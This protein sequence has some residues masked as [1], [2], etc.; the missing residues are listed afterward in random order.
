MSTVCKPELLQQ[1]TVGAIELGG[2]KT[3]VAIGTPAGEVMDEWRFPTTAPEETLQHAIDWLREKSMPRRIGVG[4]FG[5][6]RL[7]R[8]SD[9]DVQMLR[10]PKLAWQ[11]FPLGS[12]L[13]R[14]APWSTF[15][16]DT[17]V[18]AALLA[19]IELGAAQNSRNAVYLTIGTGIG[20]GVWSEGQVIHGNLHPEIGHLRVTR[21]ADDSFI[22]V[23]PFH[24]DCLEGLASGPAIETRW[25]QSA[26]DLPFDHP[27]WHLEAYYLA[28]G[29][30]S[31]QTT[32]ATEVFVLGGGVAQAPG[33]LESIQSE[34]E[35][36]NHGYFESLARIAPAALG[37]RAGIIGALLLCR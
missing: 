26:R 37:Q 35:C 9:G 24:R 14:E 21:H 22:G 36:L 19:E 12:F 25:Q 17:D 32:L 20:G 1:P 8:S 13:S 23:C 11:H 29:L 30:Y 5:P 16:W 3:V 2:T 33:L 18:N 31:L 15:V 10:T 4:S 6:I 27:A 7:N 28:Q 34:F